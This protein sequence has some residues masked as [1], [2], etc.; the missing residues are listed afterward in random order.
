MSARAPAALALVALS[1]ACRPAEPPAPA[2]EV[3]TL[4]VRA[5]V[6]GFFPNPPVANEAYTV[7]VNRNLFEGLVRLDGRLRL[8]PALAERWTNPDERTYVF[9]LRPG[10]RFSDGQPVT[11][12]DVAASLLAARDRGWVTSDYL[13][14][15]ASA[16]PLGEHRLELRTRAPYHILLF[17]L[18]WGFVLPASALT[19]DPVPAVGTGPYRLESWKPGVEARLTRNP[20]FRGTP[21]QFDEVRL[22]VVPDAGERIARVVRGEADLADHVPPESVETLSRRAD[23][24][25]IERQSLR[26]L[27]LG[28]RADRRPYSDPRVREAIDAALDRDELIRRALAGRTVP[29]SQVVTPAVVGYNPRIPKG[30]PDPARARRLLAEAGYPDGVDLQLSGP[31]NRYVNDVAILDEVARQLGNAGMRVRTAAQDKQDFFSRLG[32]GEAAFYLL[33]WSCESGDAGDILDSMFHTPVD[34][35]LGSYNT[36]GLSDSELDRLIDQS[37]RS[38]DVAQRTA[39]LQAAMARVAEL[40]VAI[41]LVVQTEALALSPAL[42]WE[43]P[44]T[45]ALELADVRRPR[46]AR[47]TARTE[48]P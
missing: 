10:L 15:I 21:P 32:R 47:R 24:R 5:D 19:Q 40:R 18:P 20:Y 30:R 14:A 44:L 42:E 35:S 28:L 7:Y 1:A 38:V 6:T 29:A 8:Q 12:K 26:V 41:P 9:D 45:L 23:L 37:N 34:G 48:T 39:G 2:P 16:E 25:V 4:A 33:G 36:L 13:H 22:V 11:A 17:K 3:L 31:R 43:P 27:F 46:A